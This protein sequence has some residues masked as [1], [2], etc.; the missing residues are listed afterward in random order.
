MAPLDAQ[1]KEQSIGGNFTVYNQYL[2][3][4]RPKNRDFCDF[5][6]FFF[7]MEQKKKKSYSKQHIRK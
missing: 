1:E 5:F 2:D 4:C 6:F 7:G 3:R